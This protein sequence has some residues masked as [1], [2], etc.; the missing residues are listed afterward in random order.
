MNRTYNI[1]T[2]LVTK[3][4]AIITGERCNAIS[5]TN[6]GTDTVYINTEPVPQNETISINGLEGEFDK[7]VYNVAWLSGATSKSLYIKIKRYN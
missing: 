5:F 3:S 7:T 2:Q 6:R 1:E 4:Q